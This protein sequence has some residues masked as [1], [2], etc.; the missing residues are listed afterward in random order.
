MNKR[1]TVRITLQSDLCVGSGYSY[2]GVI[3][4]DVTADRYGIPY[5]PARRLK[6]CMRE[7]AEMISAVL[8]SDAISELFGKRGQKVPGKLCMEN[9]RIRNYAAIVAFM[10]RSDFLKNYSREC[11]LQQFTSVRAQT[12]MDENGIAMDNTL[13][14]IRVVNQ[15][16]PLTTTNQPENLVFYAEVIYPEEYEND[17]AMIARATRSI[18]LNR[19]RG[20]GNI[21]CE[22][23]VSGA[24]VVSTAK[25]S[26]REETA[27]VEIRY[28]LLNE[29]PLM[30]SQSSD[31]VSETYIPGRRIL[32][33]LA[34]KYLSIR[35][36]SAEDTTFRDL[37][38]NGEVTQ[39]LNAYIMNAHGERCI[40]VPGYINRLKK[41]GKLVNFERIHE[42]EESGAY[43]VTGGN[44]PKK[45]SGKYCTIS[46]D[47]AHEVC[48]QETGRQLT[49]HHRHQHGDNDVQLYSHLEIAEGQRFV[50][51]IRTSAAYQELVISL[52]EQGL[53]IGKSRSAEYGKCTICDIASREAVKD[54]LD[55]RAEEDILVSLSAPAVFTRAGQ[56][57]V[58]YEQVYNLLAKDLGIE[59]KVGPAHR[60]PDGTNPFGIIDSKLI[61]GYQSIWNLHRTPVAAVS[62]GS[63]FVYH[64]ERDAQINRRAMVGNM[65]LEGYGEIHVEKMSDLPY[66]MKEH[67]I[68]TDDR[69]DREVPQEIRTLKERIERKRHLDSRMNSI[70]ESEVQKI[71][72]PISAS[73]LGRITL[74]LREAREYSQVPEEQYENY[75]KRIESIKT[76]RVKRQALKYVQACDPE[77]LGEFADQWST[78]ALEGLT[79]QKYLKKQ[80]GVQI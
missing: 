77:K 28:T 44:Q 10:E 75:K 70:R 19:N 52:L 20:L 45:L 42:A 71:L 2:A 14:F 5:I 26:V 73:A 15:I 23:D 34:A 50:G 51:V 41:S 74:M 62:E 46:R 69:T 13:R 31:N 18:G 64:M 65:R 38:L 56:E 36:N 66:R 61:H 76:D 33:A 54:I 27:P 29:S 9:A 68:V 58:Q 40:P 22:L 79:C 32:G 21:C 43:S 7:A 37:F 4:S 49:Y 78:I 48:I 53:R 3:D 17:L 8:Q 55:V 24:K 72:H 12:R 16:S 57:T 6:G 63:V 1:A 60:N 11:V 67:A 39:F 30:I 25:V 80:E 35:G 47:E 59:G